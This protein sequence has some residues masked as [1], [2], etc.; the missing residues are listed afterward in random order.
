MAT[1]GL[2]NRQPGVDDKEKEQTLENNGQ[3]IKITEEADSVTLS[4]CL[5][6]ATP[7]S[8]ERKGGEAE[9]DKHKAVLEHQREC[10]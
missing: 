8:K 10:E 2:K 3:E 7:R 6:I 4:S 9:K 5:D 1:R